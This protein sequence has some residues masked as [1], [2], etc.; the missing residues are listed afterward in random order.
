M[1]GWSAYEDELFFHNEKGLVLGTVS[2]FNGQYKALIGRM[3]IGW[4]ITQEFAKKAV[5]DAHN[6]SKIQK[7]DKP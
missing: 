4:Y 2:R 5:E 6:D 3:F 7:H 1:N